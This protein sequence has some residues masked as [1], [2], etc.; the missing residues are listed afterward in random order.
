MP[1]ETSNQDDNPN[2][3]CDE[4]DAP[5]NDSTNDGYP[6][7]CSSS[8][9]HDP[10]GDGNNNGGDP[11][12]TV[13]ALAN[14]ADCASPSTFTSPGAE[15]LQDVFDAYSNR[16][17]DYPDTDPEDLP[18]T[19]ADQ[20]VYALLSTGTNRFYE[21]V[22]D[23]AAYQEIPDLLNDYGHESLFTENPNT[24]ADPATNALAV[25]L[26]TI[27]ERLIQALQED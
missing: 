1:T 26:F 5:I 7:T 15:F 20:A 12:I 22:T 3:S 14:L 24:G 2:G 23:L 19:I 27:T 17:E 25:A 13:Y 18:H 10:Y 4:C 6:R 8:P 9:N 21:T 11:F 16:D